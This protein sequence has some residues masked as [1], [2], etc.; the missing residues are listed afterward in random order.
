MRVAIHGCVVAWLFASAL[1]ACHGEPTRG[2][3][4]ERPGVLR[5]M[6]YNVNFGLAGD[7]AGVDAVVVGAADVVFFQET[8]AAWEAALTRGLRIRYPHRQ[9][10]PPADWPAGGMGVMSRFPII[11]LEE[12]P[13]AGGPFFAWRVVLDTHLGRIQ[14]LNVHLRPPMSDGGSWV[15]GYFSTRRDRLHEIE[16]HAAALAPSLPTLIVGDFNEETDGLAVQELTRRG[17]SDAIATM[18]GNTPTWEWPLRGMTLRFQ[19]DHLLHD[20]RF[21]ATASTIVD[22]GRSDHKPVWADFVRV[23]E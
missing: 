21:V 18:H 23:G 9:F 10:T 5:V 1:S 6:S 20:A 12:L 8:N 2:A 15:V 3:P 17:F 7:R 11:A 4:V 22:A 13:P 16:A 14:V 19:L